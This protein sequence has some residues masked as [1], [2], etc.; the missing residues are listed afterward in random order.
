[1][2]DQ[3]TTS[4]TAGRMQTRAAEQ[5]SL[6]VALQAGASGATILANINMQGYADID[7]Y[8]RLAVGS[9]AG[10]STDNRDITVGFAPKLV[11]L[12]AD[13]VYEM[14]WKTTSMAGDSALRIA[15]SS[16]VA[17][18]IQ[19]FGA[20]SFQVGSGVQANETGKTYYWLAIG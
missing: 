14:I 11:M 16:L 12:Q 3:L 7:L 2:G 10:N 8:N 19:S 15:N 18:L 13:T 17:N 5:R 20:T 9:Y 6:G 1:V 4:T